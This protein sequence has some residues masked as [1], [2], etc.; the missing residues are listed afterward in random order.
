MTDKPKTIQEALMKVRENAQLINEQQ[1]TP[2]QA[3]LIQLYPT[4]R[5]A[6]ER[7][8]TT[9]E[10]PPKDPERENRMVTTGAIGSTLVPAAGAAL[11]TAGAAVRGITGARAL[12]TAVTPRL[13]P[14]ASPSTAVTTR[15]STLPAAPSTAVTPTSNIKYIG[16]QSASPNYTPVG[17]FG[18]FSTNSKSSITPGNIAAGLALGTGAAGAGYLASKGGE[19]TP[20]ASA[21]ASSTA[22]K[23]PAD[24]TIAGSEYG[25]TTR[26]SE[27]AAPAKPPAAPAAPKPA[28]SPK[29]LAPVEI[30]PVWLLMP[31]SIART[32]LAGSP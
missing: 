13:P 2:E 23:P 14:P 19:Q 25:T 4:T 16:S 11:R 12:P 22:P 20:T 21:A 32:A 28:T 9:G 15:A 6:R 18:K 29:I 5:S 24:G 1:A 3:R 30:G 31:L 26:K 8:R 17:G 27:P 7:V 10:L